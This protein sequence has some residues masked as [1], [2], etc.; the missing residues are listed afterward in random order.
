MRID[1]AG[2]I[3]DIYSLTPLQEG[4]LYHSIVSESGNYV[5]QK[6]VNLPFKLERELLVKAAE[7]LLDRY[8]VLRTAV[9]YQKVKEP[10]QVVLKKQKP[11]LHF[12]D[13]SGCDNEALAK[14]EEKLIVDDIQRGFDLQRD[15]LIRFAYCNTPG[16]GS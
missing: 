13:F 12:Y 14:S 10:K 6:Y 15:P 11:E 7:L 5:L 1:S 9:I 3:Q 16:N 2:M 8:D 4:M